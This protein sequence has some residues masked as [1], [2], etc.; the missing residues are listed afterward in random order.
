[1]SNSVIRQVYVNKSLNLKQVFAFVSLI[2]NRVKRLDLTLVMWCLSSHYI[3]WCNFFCTEWRYV[4]IHIY[5]AC[6]GVGRQPFWWEQS[7][8]HM[9]LV[10]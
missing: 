5:C 7:R 6:L 3:Y 4:C 2:T 8:L 1:V 9:G 10:N